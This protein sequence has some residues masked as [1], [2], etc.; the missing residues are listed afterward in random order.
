[1]PDSATKRACHVLTCRVTSLAE[2]V[3]SGLDVPCALRALRTRPG[4]VALDSAG[5]APRRWSIVAFDPFVALDGGPSAPRDLADLESFVQSVRLDGE[6]PPGPFAGGFIGVLSYDLGVR[7]ED[8]ELPAPAWPQPPLAGGLYGDWIAF[9]HDASGRVLDASLVVSS[10]NDAGDVELRR[11]SLLCDLSAALPPRL[12]FASGAAVRHVTPAEHCARIER[13]RALI[14]KGEVYQANLCHRMTA[15]VEGDALDL[16]LTLRDVNPA[17]YMGFLRVSLP[18]GARG[19][20]VSASPELLVELDVNAAGERIAHTRPIKGTAGRGATPEEDSAR[21][22]ALLASTKDRGELAMI[23]D[24]ERNDLGRIALAGGVEVTGFPTLETYASVHH[25]VA[26]VS[27]RVRGDCSAIDVLSSVFPGG[28]ITGAPK[29]RSM[30]VIAEIEGEGRGFFTGALGFIDA[31]GR[32][33]FN[34]LIRTLVHRERRDGT[35]EVS[36]HVGGGIT[37]GSDA[38]DEDRETMLKAEGLLAALG[39]DRALPQRL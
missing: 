12:P 28:S 23:V 9:E 35:R 37:W 21:K 7:N 36:F 8:L 18:D 14:A 1:M 22:A 33:A 29:L 13:V 19:A 16:Y 25:L 10:R 3:A 15:T 11:D 39:P 27:A 20:I 30:E 17:P 38:L 26:D 6:R 31:E 5:G 34:I 24:L 4:L 2:Q 32:A